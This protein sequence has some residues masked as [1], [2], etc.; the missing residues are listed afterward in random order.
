MLNLYEQHY[1]RVWD[2][3]RAGVHVRPTSDTRALTE[4]LGILS[5]PASPL[6]GYLAAVASNTDLQKAAADSTA[7]P[8]PLEAAG[9]AFAA[10]AAQL[11]STLGAPPPGADEPGTVISK[12][13]E[14]IRTL[15]V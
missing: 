10:K 3:I 2:D 8:N 9:A 4:L 1:V 11:A 14:P 15:M 13:F 6:K 12:H 5:S 7:A